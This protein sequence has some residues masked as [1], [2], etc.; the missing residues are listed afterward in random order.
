MRQGERD[1]SGARGRV[2]GQVGGVPHGSL[3]Q[4]SGR[5]VG[6]AGSPAS[7]G[8]PGRLSATHPQQT[9]FELPQRHGPA[10]GARARRR[11]KL[12]RERPGLARTSPGVN[13]AR[14]SSG[15]GAR[16]GGG[17]RFA[18]PRPGLSAASRTGP[19]S[20][21]GTVPRPLR[22][23]RR[24]LGTPGHLTSPPTSAATFAV[25]AGP[26]WRREARGEA[27]ARGGAGGKGAEPGSR[28][29]APH[30]RPRL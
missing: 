30:R 23:R 2:P 21:A 14:P 7:R 22:R 16:R 10:A 26:G 9:H 28:G 17:H 24:H 20:A 19:A 18:G 6:T 4:R 1:G 5:D 25:R 15:H 12:R 29:P 8:P 11:P 3:G 13:A 27:W